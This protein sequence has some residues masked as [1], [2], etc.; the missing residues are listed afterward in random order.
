MV[1]RPT[2]AHTGGYLLKK[3]G[4]SREPVA[5]FWGLGPIPWHRGTFLVRFIRT[6]GSPRRAGRLHQEFKVV[7][8]FASL[9]EVGI[10]P[11]TLS[12]NARP[13]VARFLGEAVLT[14][15]LPRRHATPLF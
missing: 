15:E 9:S 14:M 3:N 13:T 10:E 11:V 6:Q 2:V 4:A 7:T 8:V 1:A 5:R 12:F